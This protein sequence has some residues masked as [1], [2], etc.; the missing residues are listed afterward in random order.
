MRTDDLKREFKESFGVE[1]GFLRK[2]FC[3]RFDK[4][5]LLFSKLYWLKN[6][7]ILFM[8]EK[9]TFDAKNGR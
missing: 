6:F 1:K 3:V 2:F 9:Q 5:I 4:L 7:R 8:T